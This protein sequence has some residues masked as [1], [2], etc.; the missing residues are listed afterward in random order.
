M[1]MMKQVGMVGLVMWLVIAC[2]PRPP[3]PPPVP[4]PQPVTYALTVQVQDAATSSPLQTHVQVWNGQTQLVFE[5]DG[6]GQIVVSNQLAGAYRVRATADGYGAQQIENVMVPQL[7][8]LVIKL[9]SLHVD[10]S[11]VPLA[12]L[13][14]IRGAMWP[15]RLNLP[16]GPRPGQDDNILPMVYYHWFST[17]DRQRMLDRYKSVGY[18]HAVSGPI[19][20]AWGYHGQYPTQPNEPTQ[21]MWDTYLDELQ[22][23]WDAGVIPIVFIH[24]DG[25]DFERTRA[26][27]G[28]LLSQS[29]AQKLIR[30]VVPSGWEPARYEWSSCTWALY[31][32]WAREVLPNA[33][34]LLHTT[35]DVDAPVGTDALC[36][37]DDPNWNPGG[38][39][40]GWARVVPFIHGWL[41]Q[42]GPYGRYP[43]QDEQLRDEFSAQ[44]DAGELGERYHSI[45][46][47]FAGHAGW[48]TNSAWGAGVRIKLYAAEQTSYLAYWENLSY[49]ISAAWGDLAMAAGADGYLDAGNVEVKK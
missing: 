38:N 25:W 24:P 33:L 41:I 17:T 13:A 23:R 29:R 6:L 35:T 18:T 43:Q 2:H 26:V 28:P 44:F 40:A 10:P 19:V 34:V 12:E 48:P 15:L 42:N 5:G 30:V 21:A 1:K 27:F 45:A 9:V 14:R 8:P 16:F 49:A 46:W 32:Q 47:H 7:A 11:G 36:N 4:P 3:V 37:D 22:E 39:G 20:D 31:G